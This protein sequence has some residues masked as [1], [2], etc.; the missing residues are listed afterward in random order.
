VEYRWTKGGGWVDNAWRMPTFYDNFIPDLEPVSG[1][2]I[3]IKVGVTRKEIGI[4]YKIIFRFK[5]LI[6]NN[7]FTILINFQ[8]K[9]NF[10]FGNCETY[11]KKY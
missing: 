6:L 5:I 8:A 7:L 3:L 11:S 9:S 10:I 4:V 1:N 2:G